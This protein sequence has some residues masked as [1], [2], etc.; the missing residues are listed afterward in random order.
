MEF[1]NGVPKLTYELLSEKRVDV[2]GN[3]DSGLCSHFAGTL[4][5]RVPISA[6]RMSDLAGKLE[7]TLRNNEL[8]NFQHFSKSENAALPWSKTVTSPY[9]P[10]KVRVYDPETNKLNVGYS[11]EKTEWSTGQP[12]TY[13]DSILDIGNVLDR[14]GIQKSSTTLTRCLAPDHMEDFPRVEENDMVELV[15]DIIDLNL[16][17]IP[18][19]PL[20][21]VS[22]P[23]TVF[24]LVNN[25]NT[26]P[27]FL[28]P[29][30]LKSLE[31]WEFLFPGISLSWARIGIERSFIEYMGKHDKFSEYPFMTDEN[32][33]FGNTYK[34]WCEYATTRPFQDRVINPS[35]PVEIIF[36]KYKE[37]AQE[38]YGHS[39]NKP[40]ISRNLK[41]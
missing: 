34:A 23:L 25:C 18:I 29:V 37:K 7:S 4:N 10:A 35:L 26:L 36:D 20:I 24:F 28:V 41:Y 33:V 39:E 22:L 27:K 32:F 14:L 17:Q 13:E 6:T 30:F 9:F 1:K 3:V 12:R 11:S 16:S 21:G 40:F 2:V 38:L 5:D 15:I 8:V 31:S 19:E